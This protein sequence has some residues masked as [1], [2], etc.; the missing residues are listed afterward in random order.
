MILYGSG[1]AKCSARRPCDTY[2]MI[3][4]MMIIKL[5]IKRLGKAPARYIYNDKTKKKLI[6]KS[7]ARRPD[8]LGKA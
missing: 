2:V 4:R 6:L 5:I 3:K 8:V 7:S 1:P